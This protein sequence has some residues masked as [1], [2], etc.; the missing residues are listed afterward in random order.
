MIDWRVWRVSAPVLV[1]A[2]AM[3]AGCGAI[4][5]L[6]KPD[7]TAEEV[8]RGAKEDLASGAYDAAIKGFNRV[9]ALGA[10][11]L[12]AQQAQLELA[13]AQWK[14]GEREAAVATLDRFIRFNPSSPALD[15]ALYLRGM[16]NFNDGLGFLSGLA[17][18]DLAERD[19]QASRDAW[20][21]FR[22]LV[23]QFPTSRYTADARV[24]MDYIANA[25]ARHELH[26][27]RYYYLRGAYVAAANRAQRAVADFQTAPSAEEALY[28]LMLSYERLELPELRDSAER[29]LKQNFPT[30]RFLTAGLGGTERAWWQFW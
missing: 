21:S 29:V 18:Q 16:V 23:D 25:L 4:R 14:S 3:L 9:E 2:A 15:Y 27:A 7:A 8:F 30:S 10:G 17:R 24:R 26:V 12:L 11:T 6:D 20:Q 1:A 13:F 22:Q 19:Q 5:P 28:L